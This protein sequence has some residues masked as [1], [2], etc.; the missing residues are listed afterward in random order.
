LPNEVRKSF[1]IA[2][3]ASI[4]IVGASTAA[5]A[6]ALIQGVVFF[7]AGTP[8]TEYSKAGSQVAFSFVVPDPLDGNPTTD[9]TDFSYQLNGVTVASPVESVT[10]FPVSEQGMFDIDFSNDIVSIYGADI[11][12][13]GRVGPAGY[14]SVTAALNQGEP[15][16]GAGGVTVSAIGGVPEP[17]TWAMTLIGFGGL[18]GVM[19]SK[20]RKFAEQRKLAATLS[21]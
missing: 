11:G 17:A 15:A 7:G 9:V 12:S 4:A 1:V 18:G 3:L 13:T 5:S 20:N 2:A 8:T 10:F 19:R 6:T 21:A 14:Y 16:T